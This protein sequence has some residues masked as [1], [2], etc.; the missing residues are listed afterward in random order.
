[1]KLAMVGAGYVG[2]VT[3]ACFAEM[4]N[5]VTC[6]DA[7]SIK[8]E[9][10][11]QGIIPIYEPGLE[12]YVKRNTQENR[13]FFTT[14]L[15]AAVQRSLVVFIAVGTPQDRDG[16]ADLSMVLQVARDIGRHMDGYKVIVEKSTVPV[17]TAAMVRQVIEEELR[18][19]GEEIEFDVVSNP[20]FLKEG[21]ALDDFMKPDRIVAGC[22]DVRV[23]ELMKELYAPFVRTNHPI[24]VMDVVSAELTKY[25]AN[26]FLATKISFI[27]EMANICSRTGANINMVRQGI[28]SDRRIG[29]LF[30]F[31]GLG[32][33]GSCFPKDMQALIHTARSRGYTPRILEAAE[34]INQDQ[35][36]LF[37]E[38]I[39]NY[40]GGDLNG[41]VFAVWG[42]SFKPQTD[43]IRDAPALTLIEKLTA[44]GARLQAHDPEGMTATKN[45]LQDNH[46]VNFAKTSYEAVEGTDALII[47]TEWT[48]FREPD[49]ERMR[50]LMKSPVI[51]DGRNLYNPEKLDKLGFEYFYIGQKVT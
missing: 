23:A 3:A 37:F 47:C 9:A 1:M 46:A 17:G 2:L 51:F 14:D 16:S 41:R 11:E 7:D 38:L 28:G 45:Y 8:V 13:L 34:A 29:H 42:L 27:N 5:E 43:D 40:Y 18:A 15:A 50:S 32:Y 20:E 26:A 21:T 36:Q 12:D 22:D 19:R 44:A 6:V 31:P 49:F 33:G 39:S 35:R 25:A 4:G 24:I 48:K 30:L 10:L